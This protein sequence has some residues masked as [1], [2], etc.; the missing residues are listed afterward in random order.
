MRPHVVPSLLSQLCE[1]LKELL[2]VNGELRSEGQAIWT[3]LGG[4]LGQVPPPSHTPPPAFFYPV[5]HAYISCLET[6]LFSLSVMC[7]EELIRSGLA[8]C[9]ANNSGT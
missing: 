2:N 9:M 1:S 4:I 8:A 5:S 7:D 6:D 3:L